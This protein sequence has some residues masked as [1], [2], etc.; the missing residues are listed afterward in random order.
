VPGAVIVG[1]IA[2]GT[3][4][5]LKYARIGRLNGDTVRYYT[6]FSSA[7][8]VMGGTEVWINGAKVGRVNRVDFAPIASDTTQRVV[9]EIEVLEKFRDQIRENSVVR[10]RTGAKL[11]GPIVVYISAGTAD[12]RVVPAGDTIPTLSGGDMQAVT[13]SFGEVARELP[14]LME[15]VK[16]L[17]SSLSSTRG[18]IGALT[19]LDAP[20]RIEAL[21][22]NASRLTDRATDGQGTIGL[23]MKR[24]ELIARAKS[25][26]AQADSLR[27]LVAGNQT[28]LGRFRRDSSLMRNV[29]EV[30]DE[31]AITSALLAAQSGTLGRFSQDS[32]IAVQMT[33]MSKQMTELFADIKRRP[34]RYIA[35]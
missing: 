15:N 17:S 33:E 25:A 19:T 14:A 2:V 24:G 16:L 35:F 20:K 18:T 12:A 4:A 34:F 29:A 7:R 22:G 32:I 13:Q 26:A 23:A 1:V 3:A 6:A 8:A 11:M 21:V 31:L 27:V 10:L 5:T 9:V 28:S 30:R